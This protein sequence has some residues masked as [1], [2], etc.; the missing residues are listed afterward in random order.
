MI[1]GSYSIPRV[2]VKLDNDSL[3]YLITSAINL[4]SLAAH[5]LRMA[6]ALLPGVDTHAAIR[7]NRFQ[8]VCE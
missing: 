5:S 8:C 1:F 3:R 4:I 7:N 6:A 2:T